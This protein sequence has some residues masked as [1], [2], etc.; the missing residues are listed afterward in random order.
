MGIIDAH[1]HVPCTRFLPKSLIEASVKNM[2][3][4]LEANG[5]PKK[6][7]AILDS[8]LAQLQYHQCDQFVADMDSA[9]VDHAMLLLPDFTFVLKDSEL[10][11]ADMIRQHADILKRHPGRF[12]YMCGVDPGW[13]TE[14]LAIFERAVREQG[15]SG[16]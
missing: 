12:F 2:T 3:V 7:I 14:G 8:Y 10:D 1:V 9:G 13:G 15:C 11:I 16:L 6:E 5:L 4:V